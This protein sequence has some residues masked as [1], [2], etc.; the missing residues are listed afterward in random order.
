MADQLKVERRTAKRLFTMAMNQ[1][2]KNIDMQKPI[3]TIESKYETFK[4]R[5]NELLE[6]HATYLSVALEEDTEPTEAEVQWLEDI[7][8]QVDLME[9]KFNQY[10]KANASIPQTEVISKQPTIHKKKNNPNQHLK[11]FVFESTTLDAMFNSLRISI[12]C[13]EATVEIIKDAQSDVK[14]QMDRYRAAQRDYVLLL[15]DDEEVSKET[16][17]MMQLQT[18]CA[19]ENVK[20]GMAIKMRQTSAKLNNESTKPAGLQMK[21]ERMKLPTFDGVIRD[22]PRFKADFSKH[23]MPMIKSDE[24]A[25]Y[26]LKSC[27]SKEPLEIVKN[28]DDDLYAMWDRLE[29]KYGR[30]SLLIAEI[31]KEIKKLNSIKDGDNK[32]FIKLVNTIEGCYRDLVRIK[33]ETEICNSKIE[34]DRKAKEESELK[35]RRAS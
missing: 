8:M 22:Y 9:S 28:V 6:K 10:V 11:F 32:G 13:E 31:M 30:S 5:T 14:A 21:L 17:R 25:S 19:N 3:E 2:S 18:V 24:S 1:L 7:E 20:A 27:L 4:Q 23:V 33:K 34:A 26:I 12:S 35:A 16:E 15:S 29:N